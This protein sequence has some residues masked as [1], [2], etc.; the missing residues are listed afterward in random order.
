MSVAAQLISQLQKWQYLHSTAHL[1][2]HSA[3]MVS[4]LLQRALSAQPMDSTYYCTSLIEWDC[5]IK[6]ILSQAPAVDLPPAV[7]AF[8]APAANP[9]PRRIYTNGS[10]AVNAPSSIQSLYRRQ[11]S[12]TPSA[13]LPRVCISLS[14]RQLRH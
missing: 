6:L 1:G 13:R 10:F 9:H 3:D 2:R 7:V 8:L 11:I 12:P 14:H 4:A 5:K